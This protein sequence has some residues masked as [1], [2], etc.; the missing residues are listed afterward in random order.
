MKQVLLDRVKKKFLL[1]SLLFCSYIDA[2]AFDLLTA[3]Q[4]AQNH[5]PTFAA[6]QAQYLATLEK[7]PQGRAGL[8]PQITAQWNTSKN[9]V[10]TRTSITTS[11]STSFSQTG[12]SL[13]L[14]QPLFRWS[15]WET[16]KQGEL[17]QI[18]AKMQRI[19]AQHDLITRV[20]Q[21]YFDLLAAQDNLTLAQAKQHSI[22]QQLQQAQHHFEIGS[23]TIV[24]THDAQARY[25]LAVAQTLNATSELEIKRGALQ[26]IT[27]QTVDA[28]HGLK[29]NATIPHPNPTSMEEWIKQAELSNPQ[30]ALAQIALEVARR[31]KSKGM[32]E[33]FP[34]VDLIA[35]R[36]YTAQTNGVA[37]TNTPPIF[38]TTGDSHTYSNQIGIRVT[39]PLFAGGYTQSHLRETQALLEK[40]RQDLEATKL[41]TVQNVRATFLGV[42]SGLA[43]IK[44]LETAEKS[45]LSAYESNKLG[46]EVGA[47][48]NI[49]VLNAQD[50]LTSTRRDLYKARYDTLIADLKLKAAANILSDTDIVWLNS[51][52]A[53]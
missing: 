15:H 48:I 30:I 43:Q 28:V 7:L 34:T 20:A 22:Q 24:D 50:Q 12:W 1:I 46:Y 38:A 10:E 19:Q 35:S 42:S 4:N 45:A 29:S 37:E 36:N 44:A 31:E 49:D 13:S 2:N 14:S 21:A 52:L 41:S 17:A 32:G 26:Q 33:H 18:G 51:L 53:N 6:A 23:A 40:S 25:D 16:Y 5:D 39:V 3:Y 11:P 8:L 27:G 47:R 9:N